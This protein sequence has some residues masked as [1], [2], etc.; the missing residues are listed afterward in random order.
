MR[1]RPLVLAAALF[2]LSLPARAALADELPIAVTQPW[3]ALIVSFLGGPN[4][5]VK[6]LLIWNDA[7][8]PVRAEGGRALRNLP[9]D[10][11]IVAL[12]SADL[13]GAGLKVGAYGNLRTLYNPFPIPPARWDAS[14]PDPSVMPFVAQRVLTVLADWDP[15]NYLYYQRRLAEFQAR[16]S[17]SVLAGR[18]VLRDVRVCDLSGA[19]SALLRAAGC[20]ME[21]P[22]L[23]LLDS[24]S[25]AS[26]KQ[27]Q[28]FLEE[29]IAQG[30]V[31]VMDGGTPRNLRSF[32]GGRTEVFSFARPPLNQ[33]YPAF[34][35]EQY[36]SLWQKITAKPPAGR[37][38]D[39]PRSR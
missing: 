3:I 39:A 19:S 2:L 21:R 6:P 4:V 18:Q 33:D 38:P 32:L 9:A 29:R 5:A 16:L 24:W 1:G 25:R 34:L 26:P 15:Q 13:A 17:S 27:L 35:N 8:D 30:V 12:D 22:D 23:H 31:L 10:A 11:R 14:L 28:E 20:R 37:R 7:G 36:I